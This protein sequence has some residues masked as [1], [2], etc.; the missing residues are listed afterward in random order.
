MKEMRLLIYDEDAAYIKEKLERKFPGLS[1]HAA[2]PGEDVLEIMGTIDILM[3]KKFRDDFMK[4]A[5]RL[6]WIQCLITGVDYILSIPSLPKD[7]ILTSTRGIHGPQMSE[8]AFLLMLALTRKF[9][10]TVRNQDKRIWDSRR[11]S[12]LYRKNVGILGVGVIGKEIA[13]KCKAFDMTVYG[14]TRKKRKIDFVDFSHGPD[15][16]LGVLEE[17]DYFINVVPATPETLKIIGPKEFDAMKTTAFFI[18]IGRGETVDEEALVDALKKGKIAGA[19]L[20]V[21]CTEPLPSDHP[22]WGMQNVIISPHVG[23]KSDIY[24]DQ[25]LPT[26]EENLNRFLKGERRG[27]INYIER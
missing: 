9:P 22:L 12:L 14:I 24:P 10:Q 7:V 16:L 1:I 15:E 11:V 27:L 2:E 26:L 5:K 8:L 19:G 18:N 13:R 21:F 6:Q 4:K 23:G 17:V 3:A 25:V 20:D